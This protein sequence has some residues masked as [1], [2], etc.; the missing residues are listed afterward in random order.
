[1]NTSRLDS[2]GIISQL[3]YP[4]ISSNKSVEF[5]YD[6][7]KKL[8]LNLSDFMHGCK[9]GTNLLNCN[10]SFSEVLTEEGICY[11]FNMSNS[12]EIFREEE[13]DSPFSPITFL[14]I[15]FF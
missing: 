12:S 4:D 3:G 15:F 2:F 14:I 13:Y 7:L 8:A 6:V 9:F 10:N 1:M 11:T 5:K